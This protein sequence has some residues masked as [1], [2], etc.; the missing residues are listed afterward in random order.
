MKFEIG[1]YF[2]CTDGPYK[3][4]GLVDCSPDERIISTVKPG[5]SRSRNTG[6]PFKVIDGLEP[7]IPVTE[8]EAMKFLM[9]NGGP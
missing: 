1:S 3:V 2:T 6:E 7:C 4:I 5:K 8:A 9:L